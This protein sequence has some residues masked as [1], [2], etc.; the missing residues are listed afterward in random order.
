MKN[1]TVTPFT[2]IMYHMMNIGIAAL[3]EA[4]SNIQA[5]RRA[6]TTQVTTDIASRELSENHCRGNFNMK[7]EPTRIDSVP[8]YP[9]AILSQYIPAPIKIR[10]QAVLAIKAK[11]AVIRLF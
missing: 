10:A 8:K 11:N 9:R 4:V 1:P 5:K 2:T 6:A 7:T 3:P